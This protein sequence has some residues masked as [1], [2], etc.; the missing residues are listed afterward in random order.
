MC[1][2]LDFYIAEGK[3]VIHCKNGKKYLMQVAET[4]EKA[5]AIAKNLSAKK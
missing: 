2:P 1:M 3:N 5:K 4:K